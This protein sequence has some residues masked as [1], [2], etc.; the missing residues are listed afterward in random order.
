MAIAVFLVVVSSASCGGD[1]SGTPAATSG[2]D[3][4]KVWSGLTTAEKGTVCDWVASLYGGYGKTIDCHNG[5]TVGSTATQQ[6]CIDS[7]PATCA[8][9][10]GEIEQCSMQGMCPDPTVGLACLITACQ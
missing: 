5:Q 8:A 7:V 2:V 10:V 4:S 1:G 6:A 3:K 9:T